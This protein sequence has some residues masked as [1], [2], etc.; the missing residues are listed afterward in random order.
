MKRAQ[1]F[2]IAAILIFPFWCA[3]SLS[4]APPP[5][6]ATATA[7][8]VDVSINGDS[9]WIDTGMDVNPGD[10]LHITATGTVDFSD[11]TGVGPAGAQRGWADTLRALSVSS[12]G[13]GALVGQ[14]GNDRAATPFLVGA[15]ATITSPTTGR[16]YLGVNQDQTSKPTAGK[17]E[18]HI[19]RT[20]APAAAANPT[21]YDFRP[22]FAIIDQKL[23]YRV[24]DQ[25]AP[26]GNEG[27]L[28]NF[29][30][31]GSEKQVTNAFKTAGWMLPDKTNQDAVV[32][33]LIATLQKQA[34]VTVPMSTLYLF[35]RGQDYGF[36]RA[37]AVKVI[38]ER[39]H[40]RIWQTPFK[41]PNGQTLWAGAGT[42]DIGIEKDQRK[43]NAITHKIDPAVDGERDFIASTLQQAGMVQALGYMDRPKQIKETKTATGGEIKTD[44]RT[45]VIV[46]KP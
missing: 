9:L 13:R 26:G 43:E 27:D 39:D 25:A 33:A 6:A 42:H 7:K 24:T 45:L 4:A 5:A 30:L 29:V 11:K 34:Y 21:N 14:V 32:S 3:N 22:L 10:K 12:A 40:F 37:E 31:V 16:L 1:S 44:G 35:G 18:V 41:G 8:S 28:V 2:F 19:D 20:A 36:A 46:L 17:F 23:P 38:G 15:D